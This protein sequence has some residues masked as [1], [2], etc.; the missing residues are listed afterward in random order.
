[1]PS[2]DSLSSGDNGIPENSSTIAAILRNAGLVHSKKNLPIYSLQDLLRVLSKRKKRKTNEMRARM[3][4]FIEQVKIDN[5]FQAP[6]SLEELINNYPSC[7]KEKLEDKN[8]VFNAVLLQLFCYLS[9]SCVRLHFINKQ[10]LSFQMFGLKSKKREDVLFVENSFSILKKR[11]RN[12]TNHKSEVLENKRKGSDYVRSEKLLM[13]PIQDFR[14]ING[15]FMDIPI[16]AFDTKSKTMSNQ[17]NTPIQIPC[18]I[19][20]DI[21]NM[22]TKSTLES[23]TFDN[24]IN[25][26]VTSLLQKDEKGN[27]SLMNQTIGTLKFYSEVK[28]YGFITLKDGSEIFVHKTDILKNKINTNW[29]IHYS[30]RYQIVMG[31]DIQYYKVS[32]KMNRKA[33]N[34]KVLNLDRITNN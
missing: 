9:G 5:H 2:P 19:R 26:S 4:V 8:T 13:T 6:G 10:G 32:E 3:R 27:N 28:E 31:F 30:K 7:L 17:K 12:T 24:T 22:N 33:I 1:M 14:K 25:N 23:L 29:L 11:L 20:R 18:Q 15:S 16:S 21:K 34:L